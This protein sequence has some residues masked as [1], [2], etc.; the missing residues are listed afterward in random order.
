[1]KSR[2]PALGGVMASIVLSA[3]SGSS[4][5]AQGQAPVAGANHRE[6]VVTR[7]SGT[8][9]VTVTPQATDTGAQ[10]GTR[11]RMSIDK[12]YHG[13]L[14][15]TGTGEMLTA[16]TSVQNSAGYVAMERVSGT[17]NGRTGTFMLQHSGTMDRGAL[18]L[19][20]TV[21]PDSGTGQLVG[22]TG[23]M[24]IT[25]ANGRHSYEF[26]YTLPAGG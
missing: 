2:V 5:H 26:T 25:I 16:G 11:G 23:T 15:G 17:L 12:R 6:T 8:F 4:L 18:H 7:A 1:M 19:L 24:G 9:D 21:V 14:D 10:G 20:I 3:S 22:I 13:D